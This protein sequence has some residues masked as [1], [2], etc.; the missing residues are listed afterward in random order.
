MTFDRKL[1]AE[2]YYGCD[3]FTDLGAPKTFSFDELKDN[4][5]RDRISLKMFIPFSNN[6][7]KQMINIP[8]R[9][10]TYTHTFDNNG[11]FIQ[12]F[13]LVGN[14]NGKPLLYAL[15]IV[16][17]KRDP[18]KFCIKLDVKINYQSNEQSSIDDYFPLL[19]I[20]SSGDRHINYIKDGIPVKDISQIEYVPTPHLHT[21]T[22]ECQVLCND[23]N[24]TTAKS[25]DLEKIGTKEESMFTKCIK[26]F[27][28]EINL[29]TELNANIDRG[30]ILN[31]DMFVQ[32]K[33][34][35]DMEEFNK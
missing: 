13:F 19:R 34:C 30:I 10:I 16:K 20:D 33:T 1:Q 18:T 9:A 26:F 12:G 32:A 4:I 3:I 27:A 5:F 6:T 11:R 24:Y 31:E 29:I 23:T 15:T 8:K 25:I 14:F 22:N 17:S 35:I 28:K 2:K 21:N 7:L